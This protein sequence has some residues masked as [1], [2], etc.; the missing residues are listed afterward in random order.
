MKF[1][2]ISYKRAQ[3]PSTLVWFFATILIFFIMLVF[4]G[5][6]ALDS[7]SKK[8]SSGWDEITL[9][10]STGTLRSQIVLFN[11]LNY[12][13]SIDDKTLSV[14][15]WFIEDIYRMEEGKKAEL[16][17]KMRQVIKINLGEKECYFLNVVS[18][19]RDNADKNVDIRGAGMVSEFIEKSSI[20][21]GTYDVSTPAYSDLR[22]GKYLT[23]ANNKLGSR[24]INM[25]LLRDT[26]INVF[27]VDDGSYQQVNIKF[28]IGPC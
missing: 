11:L 21:V 18:G 19:I 17:E 6:A 20:N 28:Y 9:E 10:K 25:T 12:K 15:D 2:M 26:R 5:A 14:K 13:I 3:I 16:R 27:G 8:V 7:G 24:T 1:K 23:D 22:A 4:L